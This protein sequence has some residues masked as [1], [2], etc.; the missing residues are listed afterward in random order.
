VSSIQPNE[1]RVFHL[2][3]GGNTK[4]KLKFF[5]FPEVE[6]LVG[7]KEVDLQVEGN[8]YG[9][10]LQHL[11]KSYGES[12]MKNLQIQILKNGR[13]WIGKDDLTHPLKDGD[14]LTFLQMITGG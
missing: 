7:S 14:Q 9:D 11:K 10:L 8:T 4:L 3:G 6:R 12:V 2:K 1:G 13:E 5:G